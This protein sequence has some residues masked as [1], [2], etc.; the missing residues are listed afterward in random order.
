MQIY[1]LL[2][3]EQYVNVLKE[4]NLKVEIIHQWYSVEPS[5]GWNRALD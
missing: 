1:S 4:L 3:Q 5:N 2:H